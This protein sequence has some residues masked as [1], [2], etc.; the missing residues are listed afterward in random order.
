M[1]LARIDADLKLNKS[2]WHLGPKYSTLK[3][4]SRMQKR[5]GLHKRSSARLFI[6][7]YGTMGFCAA[8]SDVDLQQPV[9]GV[10]SGEVS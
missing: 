4:S 2:L 9:F 3:E 6:P 10:A 5:V 7:F 1:L 8:A